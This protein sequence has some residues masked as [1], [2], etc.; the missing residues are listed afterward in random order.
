[1]LILLFLLVG[2]LIGWPLRRWSR[3]LRANHHAT[4][5]AIYLLIFFLGL[6][7]GGNETIMTALLH[8]GG[9]AAWLSL[10][11]ILGSLLLSQIVYYFFL[12][13]KGKVTAVAHENTDQRRATNDQRPLNLHALYGSLIILLCFVLGVGGG[14]LALLAAVSQDERLTLY[15]LYLLL[16]LVGV[17]LGG[18]SQIGRI[19]RQVQLKILLVPLA[20]AVGSLLGAGLFSLALTD[21]SL[22]EGAAVGAGMGYYSLSSVLIGQLRGETL[23][24]IALL[25]N[26]IREIATLLLAPL[27]ARYL[28]R[29][30]PVAVGGATAMDTTL[31]IIVQVSGE[32]YGVIAIVSGVLLTTAVPLLVTII[33]G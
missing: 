10:G 24:V 30:A 22:A 1:M 33:L 7:V 23:G 17:G 6:S 28:G 9:R 25:S 3:L 16:F 15:T 32:E 12:L 5:G 14:R 29:L 21:M 31:P 20:V 18:G 26:I 19:L 4:N 2:A 8:L 11:A 13:E 27:L